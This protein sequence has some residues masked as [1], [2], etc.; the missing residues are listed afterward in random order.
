M[1]QEAT[2]ST[3][4]R[5][6]LYCHCAY[7]RV[8]PREVKDGVLQG[9]AEADIPFEAVPD[10]CELAARRD[11][12]LSRLANGDAP[13]EIVACYPRAVRWLF[14]AA[15]TPLPEDGVTIHNMRVLDA[16]TTLQHV[17]NPNAQGDPVNTEETP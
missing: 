7:A 12:S 14:H 15:K 11:P 5:R 4:R 16:E 1:S 2:E 13:L 8:V 9:L 3:P 6:L 10:L 17:L